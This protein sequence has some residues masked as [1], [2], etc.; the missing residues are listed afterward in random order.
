MWRQLD[1]H[2][3]EL[4]A[5]DDKSSVKLREE[6]FVDLMD[7]FSRVSVFGSASM[8]PLIE[9]ARVSSV[10]MFDLRD[11]EAWDAFN[12][13]LPDF[14]KAVRAVEDRARV[15]IGSRRKQKNRPWKRNT[16][17]AE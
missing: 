13:S 2:F 14:H 17:R 3:K 5:A 15:E 12:E 9:T 16:D 6:V 11:A 10:K 1:F 4:A 8:M 7:Q